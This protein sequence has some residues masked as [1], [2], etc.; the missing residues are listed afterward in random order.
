VTSQVTCEVGEGELCLTGNQVVNGYFENEEADMEAFFTEP[1]SQ[2]RWYKT[3]DLV[4][5]DEDGEIFF[6]GRKDSEVKISGYR[7]NLKE[8]ENVLAGYGS[9]GQAVVLFDQAA[10]GTG[11]IMAFIPGNQLDKIKEKE[12]D[13]FCRKQLPWYMIPGK[14][15]F[16]EEIPLNVNGKVD[17]AALKKIYNDGK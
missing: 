5:V 14:F 13:A 8:I 6:L 11:L 17:M 3:G 2:Q 4:K 16:V 15:I 10:D 9:I 7:V 12:L 1:V